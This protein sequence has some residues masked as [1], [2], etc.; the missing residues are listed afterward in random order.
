[1]AAVLSIRVPAWTGTSAQ[2]CINNLRQVDAA[3]LQINLKTSLDSAVKAFVK[4]RKSRWDPT[5]PDSVTLQELVSGG[6]VTNSP[7]FDTS[8]FIGAAVNIS[9][10]SD[11][12]NAKA[13]WLHIHYADGSDLKM[14]TDGTTSLERRVP[15]W[16]CLLSR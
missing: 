5:D 10:R 15:L 8:D 7:G 2:A 9:T 3:V 11:L 16:R 14:T 13:V 1:M 12:T 4:D 6:Y